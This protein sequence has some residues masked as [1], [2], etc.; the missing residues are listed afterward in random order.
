VEASLMYFQSKVAPKLKGAIEA[1]PKARRHISSCALKG[2][3]ALLFFK[4]LITGT[5]SHFFI[6][7]YPLSQKRTLGVCMQLLKI[8][9]GCIAF[10]CFCIDEDK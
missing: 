10:F 9:A 8:N 3:N 4:I 5:P 2:K 7:F 6:Y 1:I